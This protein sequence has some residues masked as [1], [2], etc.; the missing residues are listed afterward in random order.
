[1]TA[2]RPLLPD[3]RADEAFRVI[4]LS[5][6]ER[7]RFNEERFVRTGDA[8]ALH[9]ARVA[10]RQL[11]SAFSIFGPILDNARLTQLRE[12]LKALW[13]AMNEAR[14]LDVLIARMDKPPTSL[15]NA[16]ERAAARVTKALASAPTTRLLRELTS[17]LVATPPET[18]GEPGP[19]D[20]PIAVFAAASLDRLGRKLKKKGRHFRDLDDDELH[21]LRIT[22]KKLRYATEFFAGLFPS[23]KAIA[24]EEHSL[25]ALR[26]LQDRLGELQDIAVAPAQLARM[27]VP[28][29]AWPE[30]PKRKRLL[31]RADA[32][33]DRVREIK[34]F[35][36]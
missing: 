23:S 15:L 5:C 35:W 32:Q 22:T 28:E 34:P 20:E 31:K 10:L 7:F 3:A 30:M 21:A 19:A 12:E 13:I 25:Q 8:E 26:G 16:R 18:A 33:F 17:E 11:R 4:A 36:R 29:A 2:P 27:G 1:M 6:L 14:D 24:R 9:Q